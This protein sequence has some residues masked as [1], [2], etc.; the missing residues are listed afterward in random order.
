MTVGV[1]CGGKCKVVWQELGDCCFRRRYERFD[2]TIGVVRGS[3]ALVVVDTRAD[4]REAG[5]LLADLACFGRPVR[6]VVNSH[7]HFEAKEQ[8]AAIATVASLIKRHAFEVTFGPDM[9]GANLGQPASRVPHSRQQI[10]V[11]SE[12]CRRSVRSFG[13]RQVTW[14]TQHL[15]DLRGVELFGM[16]HLSCILL[17]RDRPVLHQILQP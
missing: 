11:R 5:E 15:V 4:L 6:W 13:D 9:F 12:Y 7:W 8:A 16:N 14:A 17:E 1:R 3:D 10:P 2:L